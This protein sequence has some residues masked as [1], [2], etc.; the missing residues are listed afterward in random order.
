MPHRRTH[1]S[2]DHTFALQV[3]KLNV[4]AGTG[5]ESA[6]LIV[7]HDQSYIIWKEVGG[8]WSVEQEGQSLL[9]RWRHT[10]PASR[11]SRESNPVIRT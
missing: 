1:R 4:S 3:Q 6:Y 9:S 7:C 10:G 5:T 11:L 2:I 8:L